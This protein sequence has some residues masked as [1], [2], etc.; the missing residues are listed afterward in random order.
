[1]HCFSPL[2]RKYTG[3]NQSFSAWR[4]SFLRHQGLVAEKGGRQQQV[5]PFSKFAKNNFRPQMN[6]KTTASTYSS[7][8]GSTRLEAV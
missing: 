8:D 1:M 7:R 4:A 2:L 6:S 5:F 3:K